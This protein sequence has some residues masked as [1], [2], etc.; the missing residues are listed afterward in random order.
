MKK[1]KSQIKGFYIYKLQKWFYIEKRGLFPLIL[2]SIKYI[3]VLL[4]SF[5][6]SSFQIIPLEGDKLFQN[7]LQQLFQ[8]LNEVSIDL[9]V[10]TTSF[11]LIIQLVYGFCQSINQLNK[12]QNGSLFFELCKKIILVYEVIIYIPFLYYYI[13]C[14]QDSR[15]FKYINLTLIAFLNMLIKDCDYNYTTYKQ[16]DFY[17]QPYHISQPILSLVLIV[18]V[19]LQYQ[20][21]SMSFIFGFLYLLGDGFFYVKKRKYFNQEAD[22]CNS[23]I[24]MNSI[25]LQF[26]SILY[27]NFQ[28][29]Q[30]MFILAILLM[31][32]INF[33]ICRC[34][35]DHLEKLIKS[36][37]GKI[38]GDQQINWKELDCIM[39]FDLFQNYDSKLLNS[40]QIQVLSLLNEKKNQE[41]YQE[42]YEEDKK[43]SDDQAQLQQDKISKQQLE[44]ELQI[45]KS[46]A[47]LKQ[48]FYQIIL[49]KY[50]KSQKKDQKPQFYF[51]Y[52]TFLI[53]KN[54]NL[55]LYMIQNESI[56]KNNHYNFKE[57][58]IF[59]SINK[60]FQK[61][62][63][64][65]ERKLAQNSP[66]SETFIDLIIY[67]EQVD[68]LKELISKVMRQK[69]ML[70]EILQ[71]KKIEVK[72]L[73]NSFDSYLVNIYSIRKQLQSLYKINNTNKQL[74]QLQK[75]Y[76][77]YL[78]FSPK[79]ILQTRVNDLNR[80]LHSKNEEETGCIIFAHQVKNEWVIKKTSSIL[81]NLF[82]YKEYD[83]IGQNVTILMPSV[84]RTFHNKYI[85]DFLGMNTEDV[86]IMKHQNQVLFGIKS[87]GYIFPIMLEVRVNQYIEQGFTSFG[88][89]ANIFLA[90]ASIQYILFNSQT[91]N[92][93]GI[94]EK[95]SIQL[96]KK[97]KGIEQYKINQFFPFIKQES[98]IQAFV[99][100]NNTK[101][102][103]Q[104]QIQTSVLNRIHYNFDNYSEFYNNQRQYLAIFKKAQFQDLDSQRQRE[105]PNKIKY[106]YFLINL[107][108]FKTQ[109]KYNK[110]VDIIQIN[111]ITKLSVK[112]NSNQIL[113]FILENHNFYENTFGKSKLDELVSQLYQNCQALQLDQSLWLDSC[114]SRTII[115]FDTPKQNLRRDSPFMSSIE[116]SKIKYI[117]SLQLDNAQDYQK[118]ES[119]IKLGDE[120]V[121]SYFSQEK[122][123]KNMTNRGQTEFY[124]THRLTATTQIT[125]ANDEK[126]CELY[127]KSIFSAEAISSCK[128]T[129]QTPA[130]EKQIQI[131]MQ[132]S[133][134]I[135]YNQGSSSHG[136][137]QDITKRRQ[138]ESRDMKYAVTKSQNNLFQKS[139]NQQK[140]FQINELEHLNLE[141]TENQDL[142]KNST[143][144]IFM[145]QSKKQL[146][147]QK[148]EEEQNKQ[149]L[150]AEQKQIMNYLTQLQENSKFTALI[151]LFGFIVFLIIFS[152]TLF[153]YLNAQ[154]YLNQNLT[155]WQY[156]NYTFEYLENCFQIVDYVEVD[157]FINQIKLNQSQNWDLKDSNYVQN[158]INISKSKL[159][160][161]VNEKLQLLAHQGNK[162]QQFKTLQ[163]QEVNMVYTNAFLINQNSQ[164]ADNY[165]IIQKNFT[166]S[167]YYSLI[168]SQLGVFKYAIQNLGQDTEYQIIQNQLQIG[169]NIAKIEENN[170]NNQ[171]Q[172]SKNNNTQLLIILILILI[173]SFIGTLCLLPINI[174]VQNF[175]QQ[176]L[177]LFGTFPVNQ[178]ESFKQNL[179]NGLYKNKI[180]S[181]QQRSKR[182]SIDSEQK[183]VYTIQHTHPSKINE[184]ARNSVR[185][186]S[187]LPRW[188]YKLLFKLIA[189]LIW[190]TLIPII[191]FYNCSSFFEYQSQKYDL[192][193]RI[194]LIKKSIIQLQA[195]NTLGLS[196]KIFKNQNLYNI[197]KFQDQIQSIFQEGTQIKQQIQFL[198]SSA[199]SNTFLSQ[200]E[201]VQF[202]ESI[203]QQDIYTTLI[204][205]PQYY[206]Q[207]NST[208]IQDL[209][210]NIQETYLS[211]GLVSGFQI[212]FSLQ[213]QI[214][215]F[216]FQP[217]E[218]K[219]EQLLLNLQR[220]FNLEN[221]FLLSECLII[222]TNALDQFI[223]MNYQNH[224]DLVNTLQKKIL[225]IRKQG[226]YLSLFLLVL[227]PIQL[228]V[229]AILNKKLSQKDKNP[230]SLSTLEQYR[231]FQYILGNDKVFN[232]VVSYISL[233]I[234][235]IAISY[236][237]K[238]LSI[239]IFESFQKKKKTNSTLSKPY[240]SFIYQVYEFI[241]QSIIYAFLFTLNIPIIYFSLSQNDI[242]ILGYINAFSAFYIGIIISDCDYNYS[243]QIQQ[244][245]LARPYHFSQTIL[246]IGQCI[247]LMLSCIIQSY[248]F[249]FIIIYQ[250][251]D[252]LIFYFFRQY[253]EARA[254]KLYFFCQLTCLL[255]NIN[256]M[257]TNG[258]I[259]LNSIQFLVLLI[260]FCFVYK[261]VE[262]IFQKRQNDLFESYFSL[263]NEE[264]LEWQRLDQIIKTNILDKKNLNE[265]QQRQILIIS[266]IQN[267]NFNQVNKNS[268]EKLEIEDQNLFKSDDWLLDQLNQQ[269]LKKFQNKK[270]NQ[271]V[272]FF[273]SYFV[274]LIQKNRNFI[275]YLI[276]SQ[277]MEKNHNLSMK[278]KQILSQINKLFTKQKMI[279]ERTQGSSSPFSKYL[280]EQIQFSNQTFALKEKMTQ[281][282]VQKLHLIA[283][284]HEKEIDSS[285][286]LQILQ[287]IQNNIIEIRQS[288]KNLYVTNKYSQELIQLQLL[289]QEYLS[290][291]SNDIPTTKLIEINQT[292]DVKKNLINSCILFANPGK[293]NAWTI[294]K[295]SS[296]IQQIFQIPD[297]EL[298]NQ[299]ITVLMPHIF[300]IQ[301][302]KYVND[303]MN[304]DI[305]K[306]N[307]DNHSSLLLF[308][309]NIQGYIFP[310]NLE[311]RVNYQ[312]QEEQS[313]FG[314]VA[315]ISQL[316][317]SQEFIL[318]NKQSLQLYGITKNLSYSL[319]KKVKLI[320]SLKI[321]QIFPFVKQQSS[322]SNYKQESIQKIQI[323]QQNE[324]NNIK[325]INEET[326]FKYHFE[327]INQLSSQNSTYLA[328][329]R[330]QKYKAHLSKQRLKEDTTQNQILSKDYYFYLINFEIKNLNHKYDQD[331]SIVKISYINQLN[332]FKDAYQIV[333]YIVQNYKFYEDLLGVAVL[334]EVLSELTYICGFQD[335]DQYSLDSKISYGVLPFDDIS[336]YQKLSSQ[337][338]PD[339][340]TKHSLERKVSNLMKS[341]IESTLKFENLIKNKEGSQKNISYF[342]PKN[343]DL[344]TANNNS[345]FY[346][347]E[348][349][350][351]NCKQDAENDHINK[352][353]I[354]SDRSIKID[355]TNLQN[356]INNDVRGLMI[357][358][359]NTNIN[360]T[361]VDVHEE[362]NLMIISGNREKTKSLFS[363]EFVNTKQRP[364]NFKIY[365]NK[366]DQE[367]QSP[368]QQLTESNINL[369]SQLPLSTTNKLL[370]G[371]F[372]QKQINYNKVLQ[373]KKF[374]LNISKQLKQNTNS[375]EHSIDKNLRKNFYDVQST[376][377]KTSASSNQKMVLQQ[378]LTKNKFPQ[379]IKIVN[380]IGV[381]CYITI[382]L[383]LIVQYV[384]SIQKI[385]LNKTDQDNFPFLV[386]YQNY[387]FDTIKYTNI[388]QIYNRTNP[389]SL[390]QMTPDRREKIVNESTSVRLI[391]QQ[392]IYGMLSDMT[393]ADSQL[394]LFQILRSNQINYTIEYLYPKQNLQGVSSIPTQIQN[395]QMQMTI[396]QA[397]INS[398]NNAFRYINNLPAQNP[399]YYYI[400]NSIEISKHLQGFYQFINDDG[401]NQTDSVKNY[402]TTIICIVVSI[403]SICIFLINPIYAKIQ[404]RRD[405]TLFL[406]GTFSS[407]QLQ[408][409]SSKLNSYLS[410]NITS[411]KQ[412]KNN[413]DMIKSQNFIKDQNKQNYKQ[414]IQSNYSTRMAVSQVSKLPKCNIKIN[415]ILVFVFLL[416]IIIPI[417]A[418]M[419]TLSFFNEQIATIN[420]VYLLHKFQFQATQLMAITYFC[421]NLKIFPNENNFDE[422]LF[423]DYLNFAFK[424]SQQGLND[425]QILSNEPELRNEYDSSMYDQFVAPLLK[426][427]TFQQMDDFPQYQY[428]L[429]D[430]LLEKCREISQTNL[431]R[432]IYLDYNQYLSEFNLLYTFL[433]TT[434]KSNIQKQLDQI[435]KD[436]DLYQVTIIKLDFNFE[437]L[438]NQGVANYTSNDTF[439]N[440]MC[441]FL[442][443]INGLIIIL[444]FWHLYLYAK[445][446]FVFQN[447]EMKVKHKL[448]LNYQIEENQNDKSQLKCKVFSLTMIIYQYCFYIP[449]IFF[450]LY[451]INN[452]ISIILLSLAITINLITSDTDYS[453]QIQQ[454]DYLAKPFSYGFFIFNTVAEITFFCAVV[455]TPSCQCLILAIYFFLNLVVQFLTCQFYNY[456][457]KFICLFSQLY[458]VFASLIIQ[459]A[460]SFKLPNQLVSLFFLS[461]LP[462]F[463]QITKVI[464]VKQQQNIVE[465]FQTLVGEKKS[466]THNLDKIIRFNF[467]RE[468]INSRHSD[469][470]DIQIL[471][472]IVN[473]HL[474]FQQSNQFQSNNDTLLNKLQKSNFLKYQNNFSQKQL[475]EQQA[476]NQQDNVDEQIDEIYVIK[477]RVKQILKDLYKK[478]LKKNKQKNK[479]VALDLLLN[480]FVF[481]I[482]IS[483]SYRIYWLLYLQL[484]ADKTLTLKQQQLFHSVNS[485]FLKKRSL[486]RNILGKKN[487]FDCQYLEVIVFEKRLEQSYLLFDSVILLKL[488]ILSIMKQKE[489]IAT[490]L[491]QKV[492]EM[493]DQTKILKENLN[494]LCLMNDDSLDLLNL[495]ALY[496][497]NIAFNEKDIIL[498]QINKF[499]RNIQNKE[500]FKKQKNDDILSSVINNDRFDQKTCILFASYKDSKN[501]TISQVSSNFQEIFP[502]QVSKDII[503]NSIDIII[504]QIFQN[505]HH[506]YLES[507][508]EE[509]IPNSLEGEAINSQAVDSIQK[510]NG[511]ISNQNLKNESLYSQQEKNRSLGCRM[512][513]QVIFT[514]LNSLY[515]QP[516]IIDI[517]TNRLQD[518]TIS[519]GLT[520][521]IKRINEQYDYILFDEK[522]LS[523][524][525]LTENIHFSLFSSYES[526]SKMNMKSIFPFLIG[527][528]DN[529]NKQISYHQNNKDSQ[530]LYHINLT[531][532]MYQILNDQNVK[533]EQS[534]G[535]KINFIVIQ[536][537]DIQSVKS[538][539]NNLM[540]QKS[541]LLQKSKTFQRI[542]NK[543]KELSSYQ[544]V[545][546]QLVIKNI[547]YRGIQN[548]SYIQIQKHRELNP[549]D[550]AQYILSQIVHPK[551]QSLYEKLFTNQQEFEKIVKYLEQKLLLQQLDN[552]IYPIQASSSFQIFSALNNVMSPKNQSLNQISNSNS[553]S[554][555]NNNY[556]QI[557]KNVV[558]SNQYQFNLDQPVDQQKLKSN[559]NRFEQDVI[560]EQEEYENSLGNDNKEN[561]IIQNNI[562]LNKQNYLSRLP[563]DAESTNTGINQFQNQMYEDLNNQYQNQ[564]NQYIF[565]SF[566]DTKFVLEDPYFIDASVQNPILS[567]VEC[568]SERSS[569]VQVAFQNNEK[570][571]LQQQLNQITS[572]QL[573]LSP[574]VQSDKLIQFSPQ[575][576]YLNQLNPQFQ[577]NSPLI[578]YTQQDTKLFSPKQA[579]FYSGSNLVENDSAIKISNQEMKKIGLRN[580]NDVNLSNYE[581]NNKFSAK[582]QTYDQQ[583][584]SDKNNMES[585]QIFNSKFDSQKDRRFSSSIQ[586]NYQKKEEEFCSTGSPFGNYQN[587]NI[588]E[589]KE[590]KK[591]KVQE[592]QYDIAS[593]SSKNSI[594]SVKRL[595]QQFMAD[596]SILRVI[597]AINL[598]G[599]VCF[600]TM[601]CMTWIQFYQM[602]TSISSTYQDYQVFDWPSKYI[603]SL[604]QVLKYQNA[605]FLTQ[606]S[607]NLKFDNTTQFYNFRNYTQKSIRYYKDLL[608]EQIKQME[609]ANTERKLFSLLR[610]HYFIFMYGKYYNSSILNQT[611]S[612]PTQMIFTP[613]N[614]SVQ[615]GI[616][617]GFQLVFRYANSLGNGRPEYYLIGNQLNEITSLKEIQNIIL[618][619]Q[620]NQQQQIQDQLTTLMVLI[621]LINGLCVGVIIPLYYHVQ[622]EKDSIIQLFA[623][624]STQKIDELIKTIQDSYISKKQFIAYS[625]KSS[626]QVKQT[627]LQ[628]NQNLRE[629]DVRK[630]NISTITK[631]P[632]FNA[633]INLTVFLIYLL[634]IFYPIVNKIVTQYYLNKT[635]LDLQTM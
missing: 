478:S 570:K 433:T 481:L 194:H 30:N 567:K 577:Q 70:I 42:G 402:L 326:N 528:L 633:K 140:F 374:N 378:V 403:I 232:D 549:N 293:N 588:K 249:Y 128:N 138:S 235:I 349:F 413:Y 111:Q 134:E 565:N 278:Q 534:K 369:K 614:V 355:A 127:P 384:L 44:E 193:Y 538:A 580:P 251:V 218:S 117:A 530:E 104:N 82:Q 213:E 459:I 425:L 74:I 256:C 170:N 58:Q 159:T 566:Q 10:F 216:L 371:Q 146:T 35:F 411:S 243:T 553:G 500:Q 537:R 400:I 522:D 399:H 110:N 161:L 180:L 493:Q 252:L 281:T 450:S 282:I 245:I 55:I 150:K 386:D 468:I 424:S 477:Q 177:Q 316:Q 324:Q 92:I 257:V 221:T 86:D 40:Q 438:Q 466:E 275:L 391:Y 383:L 292:H 632:R 179:I 215:N 495:Q 512:N 81:Q 546:V 473:S 385:D 345:K 109:H 359:K 151:K 595:L 562:N 103:S 586:M 551:K 634:L 142:N 202:F 108:L 559:L 57:E 56:L 163:D 61:E 338:S 447:Q 313:I 229:V 68:S 294:K 560:N 85:E 427:N 37:I 201:S 444:F 291:S 19:V 198:I 380:Y 122:L 71:N 98:K 373:K 470:R 406:F 39:R 223:L 587:E 317:L 123:I 575:T 209:C 398:Q 603:S 306:T 597:K 147:V 181:I 169:S 423:F 501:L 541:N 484:I 18:N 516:V 340:N 51:S 302:Y 54:K 363:Q 437:F 27:P 370:S 167:L 635:T 439:M 33:K 112:R 564:D 492:E 50:L 335:I 172:Y 236:L 529:Q 364:S 285:K 73:I 604:S 365:S 16:H 615:Y 60:F 220:D 458:L 196:L 624:F 507:Y 368:R 576:S 589:D 407:I 119:L 467:F 107:A 7:K 584:I 455:F 189:L 510:L 545:F 602:T 513:N 20:F 606:Y 38:V 412:I 43:Y 375:K 212:F 532:E 241:A 158:F 224:F 185:I 509:N 279:L 17:G 137:F 246:Q 31:I 420:T 53:Q 499:R 191:S 120:D 64:I 609:R 474:N 144:K 133:L 283:Y 446:F 219:N 155:D 332:I 84:F 276:E 415:L 135:K 273:L 542:D 228:L 200:D 148:K 372:S 436:F 337:N 454:T 176:L 268:E 199:E 83:L 451:Q 225:Y 416:T 343:S 300:R 184:K 3:E 443:S 21:Q 514:Q 8:S 590:N 214:N 204:Q 535:K 394:D 628:I 418:L 182:I 149:I 210:F 244:D 389:P 165:D 24:L 432:G 12:T 435:S 505:I 41:L 483:E 78:S 310:I 569:P 309:Q 623:T 25:C 357:S 476:N 404:A 238:N 62:K 354:S 321:S 556:F 280:L 579:S 190:I 571:Q 297:H 11:L 295:A 594:S 336:N 395:I 175:K 197:D 422:S 558:K 114:S 299:D 143:H 491:I 511:Q 358:P 557:N 362:D 90:D 482:E 346:I 102:E 23:Y 581:A 504:P 26:I 508:L 429:E 174:Y 296:G 503:G 344:E 129:N 226:R 288:F 361:L 261:V 156:M 533:K 105:Q 187:Q 88:L 620:Q 96:F 231:F 319:F 348:S 100:E 260:Q 258:Q 207:N 352:L 334:K 287:P 311:V 322:E 524:L 267:L 329:L 618:V 381:I 188:N 304:K 550:Q 289:Y 382:I 617:S 208:D 59:N 351:K 626:Q 543:Q 77:T 46:D 520:A 45:L 272:D 240:L 116:N 497:Q 126:Q 80:Y 547:N 515:I 305:Y 621:I 582:Q 333:P 303:F 323:A 453:Y 596:K 585:T 600:I 502:Y 266:L 164:S 263:L 414:N 578:S 496:L 101:C 460:I 625:N 396:E 461:F 612:T 318:Y 393:G 253:N 154:Y 442:L 125:N 387:V 139:Q 410:Q 48:Q 136:L 449:S 379:I 464:L 573:L 259:D 613:Y 269:I 517:R 531:E 452:P 430:G 94:T 118:K 160:N 264:D 463:Y 307:I 554:A 106:Q 555:Q 171:Q 367:I 277:K 168:Y 544:F 376:N 440:N 471:N 409:I 203:L 233:S 341:S 488:E 489:I 290:F 607:K 157:D 63:Y 405:D 141:A 563:K 622:K 552:Q 91:L 568:V 65:V 205:N 72:N 431:S 342:Q 6:N 486:L 153:Q 421:L 97:I 115:P 192:R 598:V 222:S 2:I 347:Q 561:S 631:L 130:I 599:V 315:Q 469:K 69:V 32:P 131:M 377:S 456:E 173:C 397:M 121:N 15:V 548:L 87:S 583:Q 592:I 49:Q 462:I 328:V 479:E 274:F 36:S 217:D 230:S 445:Q 331:V 286:L 4:I 630:Q 350:G 457:S 28:S 408:Q 183:E 330:K 132:S 314:L 527:S 1:F 521:K 485:L 162:I 428:D 591:R 22:K 498:M 490:Q 211:K 526:L 572:E 353:L 113:T 248:S 47:F 186:Y 250:S 519:F 401:V 434:D 99:E 480:Y 206:T 390:F 627:L 611:P 312:I 426:T 254:T 506:K 284:L 76:L 619:D 79:D 539:K 166:T 124:N 75:I 52:F 523:I 388:L 67:E 301:H 356:H 66:F 320:Q 9:F 417:V 227:T 339:E 242:S 152:L 605:Y 616:L 448:D 308:G 629:K 237:I 298:L 360:S 13:S 366:V 601:I 93:I 610:N 475:Q 239:F 472:S 487:P 574:V 540:Y 234:N 525:G 494:S 89:A 255:T 14:A 392:T 5:L 195:L 608:N 441:I 178:L 34:Y 327:E 265:I 465:E 29:Y 145:K 95:L 247:C 518:T 419:N 262:K 536:F 593:T 325:D 271:S 270:K